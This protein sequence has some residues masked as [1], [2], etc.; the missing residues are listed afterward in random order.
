MLDKKVFDEVVT[1]L[2]EGN[3]INEF[4][5]KGYELNTNKQHVKLIV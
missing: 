4:E 3:D 5:N 2:L 1:L